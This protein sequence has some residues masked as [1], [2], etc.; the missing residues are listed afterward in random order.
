M[1]PSLRPV[2][3]VSTLAVLATLAGLA[4]PSPTSCRAEDAPPAAPPA[5]EAPK[6]RPLDPKEKERLLPVLRGYFD[7][8][9]SDS[10]KYR[11][12]A[13]GELRKLKETGLDL[14]A[15][16]EALLKAVY[17]ARHFQPYFEKKLIAREDKNSE[18]LYDASANVVNVS[19]EDRRLSI[20]LPAGYMELAKGKKLWGVEPFPAIVTLHELEDFQDAKGT[21]KFPG[22]EVIKRRWDR[23]TNKLLDSWFVYAPVATRAQFVVDGKVQP[24]R[25]PLAEF[26]RRYHVDFDRLVLDGGADALAF[27]VSQPSFYAGLILRTREATLP[28]KELVRNLSSLPIYVMAS[29]ECPIADLLRSGNLSPDKITY[30]GPEGLAEWL[31]KL[32]RRTPPKSFEWTYRDDS[33]G[34]A[35][36]VNVEQVDPGTDLATLKVEAVDTKDD[37]N[38]LRIASKGVRGITVFLSDAILDLD[39]PVRLVVN[40]QPVKEVRIPTQRQPEGRPV[41]MPAK[42]ERTL[43]DTFDNQFQISTRASQYYGWIWPVVLPKI[44]VRGDASS[45]P[46]LKDVD[47]QVQAEADKYFAKAQEKETGGDLAKALE[48]YR[49][50]VAAGLSSV[51]AKAEAKVKELE[52]KVG[53][54]PGGDK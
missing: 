24:A 32:P 46:D 31:A 13:I 23:K 52:G 37:P 16:R 39:R 7:L 35:H 15:D 8:D 34:F 2:R 43:D 9:S 17:G 26:W 44:A 50:A 10:F 25:V 6:H 54:T 27:A 47:P 3:A 29:N 49:K 45:E 18:I 28:S 38:T 5:P 4:A 53:E 33:H 48:L 30:G 14:L 20:A 1:G 12:Q 51:K 42:F 40:G 22:A 41:A 11:L 21:R 36:Y 19:W